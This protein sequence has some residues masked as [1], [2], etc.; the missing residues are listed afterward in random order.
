MNLFSRLLMLICLLA[1][2]PSWGGNVA[3]QVKTFQWQGF[4]EYPA[5]G[6]TEQALQQQTDR[7]LQKHQ[8]APFS[9]EDLYAV[10]DTLS[11][12]LQDNGLPFHF[13]NL[14]PQDIHDG[15]VTL[16][17][18]GGVLSDID[19]YNAR[20][21]SRRQLQAPL[22]ALL[23]QP[24]V[25]P[26]LDESLQLL[27][28]FPGL[29]FFA[30]F[31]RG[32]KPNGTRLNIKVQEED[33]YEARLR[34]DNYGTDS[35]GE[36]RALGQ[37]IA[38]DALG[39]AEQVTLVVLQTASPTNS[40]YGFAR[41]EL[42]VLS[43]RHWLG[44]SISNNRFMVGDSFASLDL[45][46][47]ATLLEL[48][49]R[50]KWTRSASLNQNLQWEMHQKENSLISDQ[51]SGGFHEE[52]NSQGM[53]LR[54]FGDHKQGRMAQH[55]DWQIYSGRREAQRLSSQDQDFLK[56]YIRWQPV[57]EQ[58]ATSPWLNGQWALQLTGQYT[59]QALPSI[60]RFTL[61]GPHAIRAFDA[62]VA[63]VD[64]AA[65]VAL[66]WRWAP[67]WQFHA[68]GYVVPMMFVEQGY[69]ELLLVEDQVLAEDQVGQ[70]LQPG[71]AGAGVYFGWRQQVSGSLMAA[72]ATRSDFDAYTPESSQALW[73]QI[74]MEW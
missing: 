54:W 52:E 23:D 46:G 38:N 63:S 14:P 7:I 17:V 24:V 48:D 13:V 32:S 59:T 3:V 71:A 67:G 12:W 18:I 68:Q 4:V 45:D 20:L 36:Y 31:S 25:Q 66:E 16:Q 22:R 58:K 1:P 40:Q 21:Y 44:M 34:F 43:S 33:A 49:W 28:E 41:L 51:G 8:H 11:Q 61:T 65:L 64:R 5:L 10:A 72:T 60:E 69:G 26:A 70:R 56:T 42:P 6:I 57:I 29:N 73:A 74:S 55:W 35:T 30:Y 47:D 50:Y 27:E 15:I 9:L 62:G 53:A 2:V 19:I 39:L 37:L